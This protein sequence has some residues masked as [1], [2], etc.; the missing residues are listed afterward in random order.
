MHFYACVSAILMASLVH[1]VP[2]DGARFNLTGPNVCID[3]RVE[4]KTINVTYMTTR[5]VKFTYV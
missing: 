5:E 3:Q 1:G 2:T 4:N